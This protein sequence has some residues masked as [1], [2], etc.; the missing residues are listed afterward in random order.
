MDAEPSIVVSLW[1]TCY[2]EEPL[3]HATSTVPGTILH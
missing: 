3:G 2:V 1:L